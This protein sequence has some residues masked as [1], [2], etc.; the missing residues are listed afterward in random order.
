MTAD[1]AL[2]C[3]RYRIEPLVIDGVNFFIG[4][5]GEDNL[6]EIFLTRNFDS[7]VLNFYKES[8]S[9]QEKSTTGTDSCPY[10]NITCPKLNTAKQGFS[11]RNNPAE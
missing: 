3:E 11:F 4:A 10:L 2:K 5:S 6:F 9:A 8:V 1:T 7:Q